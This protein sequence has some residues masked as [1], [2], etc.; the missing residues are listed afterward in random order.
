[1]KFRHQYH[2]H[3]HSWRESLD[4]FINGKLK[5]TIKNIQKMATI[6]IEID[7]NE[8]DLDTAVANFQTAY[9]ALQASTLANL[10]QALA[11]L[12]TAQTALAGFKIS[13][14]A[15]VPPTA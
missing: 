6:S 7:D 14:T 8:A 11:D 4:V 5:L 2:P 13:F 10:G 3:H 1:M 9:D 15:S 12:Q